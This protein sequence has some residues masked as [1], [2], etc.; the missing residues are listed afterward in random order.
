MQCVT[1]LGSTGTIGH[2]ALDV[3]A[4]H[5]DRFSVHA[6]TAYSNATGLLKQCQQ[7]NP[8]V[9]VLVDEV[10]AEQFKQLARKN[11]LTISVL[12]GEEGLAQVSSAEGVDTVMAGI[13]GAA[14]LLP[15]LAAVRAGKRVLVANKEPLVMLGGILVNEAARFGAVLVPIDSEHNAIFQCM[16]RTLNDTS[17]CIEELGIQRLLLTGSGG[18]FRGTD[19][20]LLED[21]TPEQACAHPNWVMGRKISVDSATM[22]NKGLEIIEACWLFNATPDQIQVVVHPQSVIHSMVEYIDGSVLAH[23][24]AADM[25]IPIAH[26]LA[27]P[28]RLHSGVAALDL[29]AVSRLDFEPPDP[30]RFPCLSLAHQSAR[31]GGTSPAILNAANEEAVQAFLDLT[32][33]FTDIPKII[34]QALATVNVS[35]DQDLNTVLQADQLAREAAQAA[36]YKC[37]SGARYTRATAKR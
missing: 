25:R 36:I 16:P 34:E 33:R 15:T 35:E 3:L 23:L 14:G 27:W 6:L 4:R 19:P 21:V 29:F 28:Q 37:A 2:N 24:G 31:I 17:K 18:P 7:H 13:V 10:A 5:P 32:I 11:R 8:K 20:Q 12:Q 1:V 9:A 26:G 30:A 22:M